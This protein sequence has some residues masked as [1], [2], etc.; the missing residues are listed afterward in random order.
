[1][2]Q[3]ILALILLLTSFSPALWAQRRG[4][5]LGGGGTN[6]SN[7][8]VDQ[9]GLRTGLRSSIHHLFGIYGF[10]G[11]STQ[12]NS[13]QDQCALPIGD[14]FG[15]GLVYE[16][17]HY[18]FK[19]QLGAGVSYQYTNTKVK[20]YTVFNHDLTDARGYPYHLR[21]DLEERADQ[22]RALNLQFPIMAGANIGHYCYFLVGVKPTLNL[23][24]STSVHLL[25][26]TSGTYNQYLGH[27]VEMDNHG[28]R[29]RVPQERTGAKLELRPDILFS[30]EFGAEW[31][32]T[33]SRSRY[34]PSNNRH[35]EW[36]FRVA[37]F[38]DIGMLNTMPQTEQS[39]F[40]ISPT[41]PYDF[42][43]FEYHHLFSTDPKASLHAFYAGIRITILVGWYIDRQCR[44]CS[45]RFGTEADY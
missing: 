44:L 33:A 19:L 7:R 14:G 39:L 13:L 11:Y 43:T 20:D 23:L 3:R 4:A 31:G 38:F 29:K 40:S 27:F 6:Y 15:G 10:G 36:R 25:T 34:R 2:K 16:Y 37:A 24:G 21:Y 41:M 5:I 28:M 12:F 18:F 35:D 32:V 26:T 30:G 1:M 17:Q 45:G 22:M 8:R 9:Y 42:E